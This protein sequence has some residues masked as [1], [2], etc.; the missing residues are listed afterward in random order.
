MRNCRREIGGLSVQARFRT[1]KNMLEN[2]KQ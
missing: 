1:F 2:N